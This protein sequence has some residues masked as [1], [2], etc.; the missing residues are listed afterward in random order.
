M[1]REAMGRSV[2]VRIPDRDTETQLCRRT[3]EH[4]AQLA[5][6]EHAEHSPWLNGREVHDRRRGRE[7]GGSP[8]TEP[9]AS[10]DW[11]TLS[12]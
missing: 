8:A 7:E 2:R 11:S 3:G 4:G 5:G 10:G 12:V 1:G 9:L 6:A